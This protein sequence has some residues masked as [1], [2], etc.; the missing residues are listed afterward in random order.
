MQECVSNALFAGSSFFQPTVTATSK[1]TVACQHAIEVSFG[2]IGKLLAGHVR[3]VEGYVIIRFFHSSTAPIQSAFFTSTNGHFAASQYLTLAGKRQICLVSRSPISSP[4]LDLNAYPTKG[5]EY[6]LDALFCP[7]FTLL[8]VI[9][10]PS[11]SLASV[12]VK[13]DFK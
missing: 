12:R 7:R 11:Y 13:S 3:S 9:A 2:D 8:S 1:R 5:Q 6:R 10:L 4:S